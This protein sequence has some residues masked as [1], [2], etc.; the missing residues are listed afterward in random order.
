MQQLRLCILTG[1]QF[2]ETFENAQLRNVKKCYQFDF[3]PVE[4][5]F[6]GENTFKRQ[7]EI[8]QLKG[9]RQ[10]IFCGQTWALCPTGFPSPSPSLPNFPFNEGRPKVIATRENT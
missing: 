7:H 2:E 8:I 10:N 1:S 4:L 5:T 3:A 6:L 9:T